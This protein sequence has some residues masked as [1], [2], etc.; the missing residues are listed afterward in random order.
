MVID[1]SG[2]TTTEA[3]VRAALNAYGGVDSQG[4]SLTRDDLLRIIAT[5]R[6]CEEK[7][8]ALPFSVYAFANY[9]GNLV[10][11]EVWPISWMVTMLGWLSEEAARDS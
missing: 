2:A 3:K 7:L 8:K 4:S 1:S 9:A 6:R 10:E 5:W 11:L